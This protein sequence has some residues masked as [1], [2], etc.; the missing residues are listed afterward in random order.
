MKGQDL[1]ARLTRLPFAQCGRV[2]PAA[3]GVEQ[4]ARLKAD[5]GLRLRLLLIQWM[6]QLRIEGCCQL[7]LAL[8]FLGVEGQLQD[9]A[10]VPVEP[11]LQMLEQ[12]A[13]MTKTTDNHLRQRGA[14]GG[15]LE[16]QHT[17][18]IA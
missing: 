13:G 5:T 11:A 14:M 18:R 16:V 7:R 3:L 2:D 1:D 9:P 6:D 17:L 10:I 8:G 4:A 12:A 15:Q